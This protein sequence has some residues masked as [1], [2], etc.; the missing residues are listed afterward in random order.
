MNFVTYMYLK[1]DN[2]V[3]FFVLVIRVSMVRMYTCTY[4]KQVVE[5]LV[6]QGFPV[7]V[8]PRRFSM[9]LLYVHSGCLLFQDNRVLFLV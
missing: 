9:T 6:C 4:G 1:G 2:L 7:Y 8:C 3:L 5:F